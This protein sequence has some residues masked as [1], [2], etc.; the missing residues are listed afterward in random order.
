[1]QQL[2]HT[3][4]VAAVVST[5][6]GQQKSADMQQ[7]PTHLTATTVLYCGPHREQ[8][9]PTFANMYGRNGCWSDVQVL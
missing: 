5:K 4:F 6:L 8:V 2:P 9:L 1:V 3:A 7:K